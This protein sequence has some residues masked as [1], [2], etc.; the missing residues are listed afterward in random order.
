MR[1]KCV[2]LEENNRYSVRGKV[3]CIKSEA[4]KEYFKNLLI[5]GQSN[6]L[7]GDF[8]QHISLVYRNGN[9]IFL[10]DEYGICKSFMRRYGKKNIKNRVN[11][12]KPSS[13][14]SQ[15]LINPRTKKRKK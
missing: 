8:V 14:I 7:P 4:K 12:K 10:R 5:Y 11:Y 2:W 3:I 13:F 1:E 15:F 9:K 6:L